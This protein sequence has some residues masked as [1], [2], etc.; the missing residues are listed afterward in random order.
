MVR[1][2]EF[3]MMCFTKWLSATLAIALVAGTAL[4]ADTVAGGTVKS[5]NPG[6]KTLVLTDSNNKDSTFKLGDKLV[7][8]RA[9]KESTSDLKAG[10][11]I[12][13][14]YDK[15]VFTSTAN[16]ILVQEGTYKSSELVR[17]N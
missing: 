15:G 14:C 10:D 2:K 1:D 16:Y 17:G 9:G 11:A 6:N 8:N 13:I 3:M 7:V 12:N 4:A 5:I